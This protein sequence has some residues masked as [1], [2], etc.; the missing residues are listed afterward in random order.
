MAKKPARTT[1]KK[2]TTKKKTAAAKSKVAPKKSAVKKT[3]QTVAASKTPA[4]KKAVTKKAAA[5]STPAVKPAAKF[6]PAAKLKS[7]ASPKRDVRPQSGGKT[8][9]FERPEVAPVRRDRSESGGQSGDTQ[10]I[11]EIEDAD[12]E[13]V[14]EL[15]EEGQSL[16]A[17]VI[18]GVEG[19]PDADVSE[20]KTH[21]VPED[22]VPEE[23][24]GE[25]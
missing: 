24:D 6:K 13:S 23:Y 4:S 16:E 12:S 18:A 8:Y 22:D 14:A 15:L 7:A 3:A 21:E 10:G 20:V 5:K 17:E 1:K 25:Q 9:S 11:S 2:N 19:A